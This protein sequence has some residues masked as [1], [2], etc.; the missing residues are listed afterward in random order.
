MHPICICTEDHF[1]GLKIHDLCVKS[2]IVDERAPINS[3]KKIPHK[4]ESQF[5]PFDVLDWFK[6]FNFI[7]KGSVSKNR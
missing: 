6:A 7:Y 4:I 2:S 1:N 3:K 5:I